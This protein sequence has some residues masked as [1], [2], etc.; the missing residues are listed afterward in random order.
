MK[1]VLLGGIGPLIFVVVW[2]VASSLGPSPDVL[3][4][5]PDETFGALVDLFMHDHIMRDVW[6]TTVRILVS[7][8]LAVLIGLPLG[9]VL[10]SSNRL[11]HSFAFVID[12]FR[13]MPATAIFPV[14]LLTFGVTDASKI[15][16]AAFA[17]ALVILFN[18]AYGVMNAST[19]RVLVAKVMGA[20]MFKRFTSVLFWES[21][22]QTF[23]GF[24]TS[25]NFCLIIIV[26]TEMFVGTT[27][28]LGRRIVDFQ[29]I[30]KVDAMYATIIITGILG[31]LLNIAF[32]HLQRRVVHWKG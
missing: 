5:G 32:A 23:V 29:I 8:V 15:A 27:V 20:S 30:Y 11:Y 1:R 10:G 4:P 18:T 28:G 31:Y 21:L 7:F 22:P 17:G 12:F 26:V 25:L 2:H 9:L 19:V 6:A 13:S 14:F 3:V 24:R 16:V